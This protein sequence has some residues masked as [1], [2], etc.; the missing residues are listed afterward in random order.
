M[1]DRASASIQIGGVLHIRLVPELVAAAQLDGG[2]LGWD[3][4]PLDETMI[5][6]GETLEV[7]AT[8]LAWGRFEHLEQF[9]ITHE[10]AF[11]LDAGSCNGAFGPERALYDGKGNA[12]LFDVSEGGHVV[13]TLDK[14]RALGSLAAIEA[15]FADAETPTPSLV[16]TE[17]AICPNR[18]G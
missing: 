1:A 17:Q 14:V 12:R 16:I 15:W 11:R 8:G 4:E 2:S 6:S 10:L 5:T 13:V 18:P 7:C 3:E 9:C